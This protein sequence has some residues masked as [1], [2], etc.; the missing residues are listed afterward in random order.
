MRR[1]CVKNGVGFV[2]FGAGM[3]LALLCPT[4][5]VLIV[6]AAVFVLFGASRL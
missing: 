2:A 1:R 4:R 3:L 5:F 6:V